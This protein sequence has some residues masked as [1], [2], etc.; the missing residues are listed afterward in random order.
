MA[1]NHGFPPPQKRWVPTN[2]KE[3][4]SQPTISANFLNSQTRWFKPWPFY[5]RFLEVTSNLSKGHIFTPK[6]APAELPGTWCVFGIFWGRWLLL[7]SEKIPRKKNSK[8]KG[9]KGIGGRSGR[10]F[11]RSRNKGKGKGKGKSLLIKLRE[12]SNCP[13]N[14]LILKGSWSPSLSLNPLRPLLFPDR[15]YLGQTFI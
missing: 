14:C 6:R 8:R 10:R 5:P 13:F 11:V 12:S 1:Q 4:D 7:V 3:F 15:F 2:I 9:R